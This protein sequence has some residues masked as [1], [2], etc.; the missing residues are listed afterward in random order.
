MIYQSSEH[1]LL[2]V[3]CTERDIL[4]SSIEEMCLVHQLNWD[5]IW[6]QISNAINMYMFIAQRGTFY[7]R[8]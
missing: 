2:Y 5:Q 7:N 8:V 6:H 4:Q 1:K 3:Y